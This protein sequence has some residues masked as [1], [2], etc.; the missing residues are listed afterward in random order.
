M[1]PLY[2]TLYILTY[3]HPNSYLKW[4]ES[5]KTPWWYNP[6]D[7][8]L[9]RELALR[10]YRH[11]TQYGPSRSLRYLRPPLIKICISWNIFPPFNLYSSSSL[12]ETSGPITRI[13]ARFEGLDNQSSIETYSSQAWTPPL[14]WNK[15]AIFATQVLLLIQNR[16]Q[17]T[18]S[19]LHGLFE[20][21]YY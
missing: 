8:Y 6:E 14:L 4:K 5:I 3:H 15:N 10:E 2:I 18:A 12:L 1:E 21:A 16:H 17:S 19:V 7:T 9:E 11:G 13:F 20:V